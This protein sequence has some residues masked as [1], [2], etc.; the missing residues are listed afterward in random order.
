M[1]TDDLTS[2]EK[3]TIAGLSLIF[4]I[5]MFGLFIVLPVI[6][7][8]ARK[9]PGADPFWLGLALGGYG[10]TQALFQVPFGMLSDK[11]GRKP[12]IILGLLVFAAGSVVAAEAHSVET[13]FIGRLLQ[14][15]GA[16]ASVIIALMADLTRE[17]VR[18]R[19]MAGIGMSIGLA[20]AM[21]MIVGPIV[22][23]HWD[24]SV[25]F[26]MTAALSLLSLVILFAVVPN[27][28]GAV[29]KNEMELSID[30]LGYVLR[31]PSLL[32]MDLSVFVL[33]SSLTAV[34]VSFP[35]LLSSYMPEKAMWHVY[36]PV[37]LSG[38]VLMVPGMIYAEK[39]KKLKQ[40][41]LFSI[42]LII[43]SFLIFLS[44]YTNKVGLIAGLTIFFIGF[45]LLEPLMPSI[46]T[47]FVRTK[48]RGTSSGVFN[49]S[50]FLGAF[51]GG[52]AG[53]YLVS[54]SDKVLFGGLLILSVVWFLV[55][56]GLTDPNHLQIFEREL[57]AEVND[58]SPICRQVGAMTGVI[59]CRYL[60]KTKT[61]WVKY[62]KTDLSSD[63]L[64]RKLE[65]LI[66][67]SP[68]Q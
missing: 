43:V 18:T 65:S 10:L 45:N 13:L 2:I 29:Q 9:L 17:E 67:N 55:S 14:G 58:P 27:P 31:V 16:I 11:F 48:T 32:R 20:F 49:M 59:D 41:F 19:A 54:I 50:Q 62:L 47:R 4:S 46:M 40:T 6:S 53:G 8:Y 21:G 36:L 30:Q 3:K 28:Q 5:R 35:I 7:L 12:I 66:A 57:G 37:I 26:W 22:G 38:L 60:E 24:V 68:A 1:N 64:N 25:L 15:A 23:A 52:S 44:G 51:V 33:H 63:D 56:L 39:K 61:L 42:L 34:F